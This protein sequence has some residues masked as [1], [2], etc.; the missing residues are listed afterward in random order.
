[1]GWFD[2]LFNAAG[3]DRTKAA[4][5]NLTNEQRQAH[6][7]D[8]GVIASLQERVRKLE[9]HSR[10]VHEWEGQELSRY[11]DL[12]KRTE[13]LEGD[14]AALPHP[15]VLRALHG[16]IEANQRAV[17][18][19]MRAVDQ[20]AGKVGQLDTAVRSLDSEL[21][22]LPELRDPFPQFP[23]TLDLD[24]IPEQER[25]MVLD[26]IAVGEDISAAGYGLIVDEPGKWR[27]VPDDDAMAAI[28]SESP[29][30]LHSL[31]TG[32]LEQ[33]E[34][35]ISQAMWAMHDPDAT[36]G[37]WAE[38][39]GE[40]QALQSLWKERLA[41]LR[42]AIEKGGGGIWKEDVDLIISLQSRIE[43]L[44]GQG[45]AQSQEA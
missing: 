3:H 21:D 7:A 28:E 27:V 36:E 34:W 35:L 26:M 43:A 41:F 12:K 14:N 33:A 40:W 1:M 30:L 4:I 19:A 45:H 8:R 9:E 44:E 6:Q 18:Q 5:D 31:P 16:E 42:A 38:L 13:L 11:A 2:G 24:G 23:P 29:P 32:F 20:L 22:R 25:S 37:M 15:E 39:R 17:E 10:R